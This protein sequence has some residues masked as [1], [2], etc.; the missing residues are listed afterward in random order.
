ML[1]QAERIE[2][3]GSWEWDSRNNQ[4]SVSKE[5]NRILGFPKTYQPT[6]REVLDTTPEVKR[7]KRLKHFNQREDCGQESGK[8]HHTLTNDAGVTRPTA[9]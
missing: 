6:V 5:Y 2:Q 4:L 1:D 9:T 3:L 7:E 8:L